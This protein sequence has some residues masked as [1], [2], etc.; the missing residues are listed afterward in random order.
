MS[1]SM[2]D[3]QEIHRA[4]TRLS[5]KFKTFWTFH[6]FLQGI[7]K[8]F[9]ADEPGYSVDFQKLY[10][11]IRGIT[12]AMGVRAAAR[13]LETIDRLDLQLDAVHQKILADDAKI[14]PSYVRR[15]LERVR[16]QDEKLLIA[17]LRFY[18]LSG[19][20]SGDALDKVDFLLTSVGVRQSLDDGRFLPRFP[21]ELQKLFGGLL[22]LSK[23]REAASDASR[24]G[25]I[26]RFRGI[27]REIEDCKRFE[28]LTERKALER[29]REMKH[30]LGPAFFDVEVITAVLE[31]NVAA[32]NK[33][34]LL[35]DEE[36]RRIL[37]SSRQLLDMEKELSSYPDETLQ[38]EF[39]RFRAY[40]ELF[41]RHQKDGEVKHQEVARLA[42]SI[43]QLF[44]RLEGMQPGATLTGPISLPEA[45][46]GRTAAAPLE[47][48]SSRGETAEPSVDALRS[49]P[50]VGESAL[51][52]L[53][54]VELAEVGTGS[55]KAARVGALASLRLEPWEVRTARRVVAGELPSSQ[56]ALRQDV[57]FFE[58]AALR[59]RIDE[60]ARWFRSAPAS[61]PGRSQ[62]EEERLSRCGTCLVRAQELDRRFRAVLEIAAV[63]GPPERLNELHRSRFR[64]LRAFSGLW[65][66]HNQRV[67]Q[68]V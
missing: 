50:L 27:K 41:E 15:F 38:E 55:G 56:A 60:E 9:F 19:Y 37:D 21:Q 44:S 61:E 16:T 28:E 43:E 58:A 8:A 32:K 7:H 24:T 1:S 48:P 45:L 54:S 18:F 3:I 51:Q 30:S 42:E 40:R 12:E 66:I 11:E 34:H 5:E 35:W 4:F 31:A 10:D 63:S 67:A 65:L 26:A 23:R 49:D 52:I 22:A 68:P 64:L 59:L 20:L 46:K 14:A 6:Q 62:S 29:L 47:E 53:A 57:L 39:R 13:V 2:T 36:E 25:A 33:F 17:L